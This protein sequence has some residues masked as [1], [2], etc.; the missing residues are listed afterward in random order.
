VIN[1]TVSQA[2]D[3]TVDSYPDGSKPSIIVDDGDT[4]TSADGIWKISGATDT[5]GKQS[6]FSRDVGAEYTY[7]SQISGHHE[8]AMWWSGYSTRCPDVPVEI[9]DGDVLLDVLYV[10]Q[11]LNSG[12]WNVL[13]SYDFTGTARVSV[14]SASS[15]CS[16]AADAVKFTVDEKA[17][18]VIDDGDSGTSSKGIWKIS[19]ATDP[20]GKQ[21]LFSKD[22]GAEYTYESQISGYH[23]VAMWWSGYSTRCAD[24]PVEIFD[25]GI[26]IDR[27]YV[28]QS[29]N[30]GQWNILGSYDFN[31]VARVRISSQSSAC[32]TSADA[33]SFSK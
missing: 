32:S 13:G 22:V 30:S 14:Q 21:S 26:L 12:Q 20:F 24:V 17:N 31:G 7:E 27:V 23:E 10:D 15:D 6:L 25:D 8:V 19:G 3:D 2:I 18:N 33:V 16:T 5:F 11:S 9:Y 29:L 4:G 1:D 28:D